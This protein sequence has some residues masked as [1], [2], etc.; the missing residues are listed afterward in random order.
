MPLSEAYDTAVALHCPLGPITLAASLQ[1]DACIPNAFIQEQSLG[2]HYN[3]GAK[4]N[5]YLVDPS[6]FKYTDGYVAIPEGTGLGIEINEKAVREAA[7]TGHDWKNPVWRNRDGSV[8]EW[9]AKHP[10]LATL[11]PG[12]PRNI[13][14]LA[15]IV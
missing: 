11:R 4:L 8:A 9:W 15:R 10:F 12:L 13:L 2:I 1:L 7:K 5:D 3:I 6:V 14:A